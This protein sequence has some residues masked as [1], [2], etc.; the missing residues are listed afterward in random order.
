MK[1]LTLSLRKIKEENLFLVG[2]KAYRLSELLKQG[3]A[4]P[5][6]FVITTKAYDFFLKEHFLD[7]LHQVLTLELSLRDPFFLPVS[8]EK[9]F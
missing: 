9:K 2:Q 1:K 4:V 8:C 5:E 7:F 3:L 6:A